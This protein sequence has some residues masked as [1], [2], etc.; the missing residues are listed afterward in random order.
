MALYD[1]NLDLGWAEETA[2]ARAA[3]D[4]GVH[5][6]MLGATTIASRWGIAID[7]AA[8]EVRAAIDRELRELED[9]AIDG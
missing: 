5:P 8:R 9:E 2:R 1:F 3:W 7:E 4:M 6:E